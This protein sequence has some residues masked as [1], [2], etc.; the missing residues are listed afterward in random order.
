MRKSPNPLYSLVFPLRVWVVI[1]LFGTPAVLTV[2]VL[3]GRIR[4]RRV[5]H[6]L[7]RVLFWLAGIPVVVSGL[8]NLPDGACVLVSNHS[9]YLDGP[10]L[11]AALPPRFGFVIKREAMR[12]PVLGWLLVRLGSEFVERF[13]TKAARQDANRLI[14]L[15]RDGVSLGVFPEGTFRRQPGLRA[16]HLGAFLAATR[17]G[18]PVVPVVIRGARGILPA[19]TLRPRPGR[20]EVELLTPL[21]PGGRRGNDARVLRDAV[22]ASILMRCGEPDHAHKWLQE[23]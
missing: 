10:L 17:A 13:N 20:V 3:P 7:G 23:D 1:L 14:Q 15:A 21:L 8:Q 18:V 11:T 22:R 19:E 9:T 4:R 12:M 6:R 5:A 2:I 16:F